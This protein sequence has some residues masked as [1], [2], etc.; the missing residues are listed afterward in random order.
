MKKKLY[1][2]VEKETENVGGD[3]QEITGN[4]SVRVYEILAEEPT[5]FFSLDLSLND[6]S[7]DEIQDWLD[8][9]GYG[10]DE[11]ELKQL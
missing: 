5:Q 6:N 8:D 10:D 9:N 11:F 3:F 7:E 2:V 1:Y 4:K